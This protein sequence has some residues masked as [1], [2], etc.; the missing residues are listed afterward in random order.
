VSSEESAETTQLPIIRK[1]LED[2][3]EEVSAQSFSHASWKLPLKA[4]VDSL[5]VLDKLARTKFI[6]FLLSSVHDKKPVK[7]AVSFL[8]NVATWIKLAS[9]VPVA[10]SEDE[11]HSRFKVGEGFINVDVESVSCYIPNFQD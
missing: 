1:S 4:L 2:F 10:S 9:G 5:R 8:N 7:S 3:V 11:M 6:D